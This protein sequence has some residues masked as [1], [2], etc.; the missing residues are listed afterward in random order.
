[1]APAV[2]PHGEAAGALAVA[3]NSRYLFAFHVPPGILIRTAIGFAPLYSAASD[4]P[5]HHNKRPSPDH[6]WAT[7]RCTRGTRESRS[8]ASVPRP[9]GGAPQARLFLG[10][11]WAIGHVA[12]PP[13]D[14]IL[15]D[16]PDRDLALLLA[17]P[18]LVLFL[19][20]QS[21]ARK[22]D[23]YRHMSPRP[24]PQGTNDLRRTVSCRL[25]NCV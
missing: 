10:R 8:E 17:A 18:Q 21:P 9:S 2:R 1:M 4:L 20:L 24:Y 11:G 13:D 12:R 7:T 5:G 6:F 19:D 16:L 15:T 14:E 25:S 22:P 3:R 23:P